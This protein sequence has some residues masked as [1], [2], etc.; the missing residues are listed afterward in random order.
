MLLEER[1]GE[2]RISSIGKASEDDEEGI[3]KNPEMSNNNWWIKYD[4]KYYSENDK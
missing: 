3:F 2:E 1:S 4:Y